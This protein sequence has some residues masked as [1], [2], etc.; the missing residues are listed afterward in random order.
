MAY[1]P[2][3]RGLRTPPRPATEYQRLL[4]EE[5]HRDEPT[6]EEDDNNNQEDQDEP[7]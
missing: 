1:T 5:S 4:F 2:P 6:E 7:F 3:G